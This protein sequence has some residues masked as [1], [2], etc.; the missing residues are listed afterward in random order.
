MNNEILIIFTFLIILFIGWLLYL[1]FKPTTDSTIS[2]GGTQGALLELISSSTPSTPSTPVPAGTTNT[3]SGTFQVSTI[4][5][6]SLATDYNL[7]PLDMCATSL[8]TGTKRCPPA[9]TRITYDTSKEVCNSRFLCDNNLTPFPLQNDGSTTLT[10]VCSERDVEEN[11]P[12]PCV[13]N[14]RCA[15]Y[16]A[17]TFT[18]QN[19]SIFTPLAEQRINFIQNKISTI[20][21]KDGSPPQIKAANV[22]DYLQTLCEV[23]FS[24]LAYA[25]PGCT[26]MNGEINADAL[27]VC[28][29][30]SF[31]NK[32]A[33]NPCLIGSL[34][35][36]TDNPDSITKNNLG[37]FSYGCVVDPLFK[38]CPCIAGT[39][40]SQIAVYDTSYGQVVC[41][42][43]F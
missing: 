19:G 35:L 27:G 8:L 6:G 17:T 29:G 40:K 38:S 11:I 24:F 34:A 7:C 1:C 5:D 41:K 42:N 20:A 16:I 43:I 10:G 12:C 39:E 9:G 18:A 3:S 37:E 15:N 36:I 2:G 25:S 32:S 22:D 26:N 31:C 33:N 4:T 28:M 13:S 23:P 30:S 14:Y 21:I